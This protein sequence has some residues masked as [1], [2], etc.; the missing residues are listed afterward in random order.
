MSDTDLESD[1]FQTLLTDALRA[2]PGSPEWH[3][4]VARL[5]SS[6]EKGA[7]E[8]QLL[9]RAREDL[10]SG[11]EYRTVKAGPGFTR[12]VLQAIEDEGAG[13]AKGGIPSANIVAF[14][15]AGVILA[16]V[17]VVAVVLFK[18]GTPPAPNKVDQLK[19]LYFV[20]AIS[21]ADFETATDVPADFKTA[22]E[23]ALK[24]TGKALR[25]QTL[26]PIADDKRE[27][28]AGVLVKAE[29]IPADQ[30]GMIEVT[31]FANRLPTDV[32]IPQVFVSDAPIDDAKGTSSHE[33][34]WLLKGGQPQLVKPDMSVPATGPKLDKPG[35]FTVKIRFDKDT[36][37]VET[38]A[39]RLYEG[40]HG[41]AP[42]SPKYVGVRFLRKV[43]DSSANLWLTGVKV[44]KP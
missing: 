42:N 23:L 34:V 29:P 30:P 16:V 4:A 1:T 43:G 17:V 36:A 10:E 35:P 5:R 12:N 19:G 37:I 39:Q 8:L 2:G 27:Y 33:L 25:P 22:G 40:P 11:K 20:S 13:G 15:A 32:V 14:V 24:I 3:Q 28:R 9:I 7:D 31:F 21:S 6:G 18:T 41:L 38:G 26:E 44:L